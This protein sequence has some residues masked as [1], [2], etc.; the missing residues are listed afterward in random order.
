MEGKINPKGGGWKE[1]K[2]K[3]RVQV[4]LEGK[5]SP[6]GGGWKE[7]KAKG[8]VQVDLARNCTLIELKTFQRRQRQSREKR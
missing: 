5:I 8:R 2:A 3:G 6:K 7:M 1:M 4:D